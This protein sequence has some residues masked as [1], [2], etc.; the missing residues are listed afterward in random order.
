MKILKNFEQHFDSQ[1]LK[2]GKEY[3]K[4][5]L[6]RNVTV[7]ESTASASVKGNSPYRVKL[8]IQKKV[9]TCTCPCDFNC[10]H[11]AALFY[12][13][14]ENNVDNSSPILSILNTKSKKELIELVKKM[15]VSN[16]QILTMLNPDNQNV[17]KQIKQLWLRYEDDLEPFYLKFDNIMNIIRLKENRKDL[18]LPLFR[19]LIDLSDHGWNND[20][21][22]DPCFEE[23]LTLLNKELKKMDKLEARK[24]KKEI[25]AIVAYQDYLL[26]YID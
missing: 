11:E 22:L 9:F 25:K 21:E 13:L 8:D 26:D 12:Y 23:V 6:V 17:E 2:D 1:R 15:A 3:F 4:M 20:Q 5:G 10:K 24:L 16:P 18:L 14:R 19:R 7:D